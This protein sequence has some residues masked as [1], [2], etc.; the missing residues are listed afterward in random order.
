MYLRAG[1][2]YRSNSSSL[3]LDSKVLSETSCR[4]LARL[5]GVTSKKSGKCYSSGCEK[6]KLQ[7][8]KKYEDQREEVIIILKEVRGLGYYFGR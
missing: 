4:F 1:E 5:H 3:K 7:P 2:S 6:L 8:T